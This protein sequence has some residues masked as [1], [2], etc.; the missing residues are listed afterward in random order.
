MF[1]ARKNQCESAAAMAKCD[2][3]LWMANENSSRDKT[4]YRERDFAR[5]CDNLLKDRRSHEAIRAGSPQGMDKHR[6][7]QVGSRFK[8][9]LKAGRADRHTLDVAA[10]LDG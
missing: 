4:R 7:I 8:E 2:A 10:D 9:R 5:K 6:N 3:Q 1:H